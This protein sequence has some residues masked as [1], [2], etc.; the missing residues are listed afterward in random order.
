MA[1]EED[2]VECEAHAEGVDAAAARDQQT[3]SSPV[4]VEAGEAEQTGMR[5]RGDRHL[6]AKD[7]RRRKSAEATVHA[8]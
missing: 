3:G 4:E 5:R 6:P 2:E 7:D 1:V 8:L